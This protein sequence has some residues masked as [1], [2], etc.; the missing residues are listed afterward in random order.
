[1]CFLQIVWVSY[2][3]GQEFNEDD[4]FSD[5]D[6]V[7]DS[8]EMVDKSLDSQF[9]K[10]SISLSGSIFNTSS[11]TIKPDDFALLQYIL[12]VQNAQI[13]NQGL[14]TAVLSDVPMLNPDENPV[15]TSFMTGNV[16]LDARLKGG[17]KGLVNVEG[18]YYPQGEFDYSEATEVLRTSF[19]NEKIYTDYTLMEAFADFNILRRIYF[20]AGKQVLQWGRGLFFNPTDLINTDKRNLLDMNAGLSMDT[21]REGVYGVKMHIPFGTICNIYGFLNTG[22]DMEPDEFAWAGKIEFLLGDTEVALSGWTKKDY[23]PIYGLD[24]STGLFSMNFF[25]EISLSTEETLLRVQDNYTVSRIVYTWTP[26]MSFG[27]RKFFDHNNVPSR[28][29]LTGEVYYNYAGYEENIFESDGKIMALFSNGLYDINSLSKWYAIMMAAYREFIRDDMNLSCGALVNA[30]DQSY[31]LITGLNYNF[32]D[33]LTFDLAFVNLGG[34]YNSEYA[35]FL[36]NTY[37]VQLVTKLIF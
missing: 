21:G 15:Y 16:I 8:E 28:V 2:V 34:S 35:F 9:N 3:F 4:L 22:E 37:R 10:R 17:F 29:I 7:V 20:R 33:H 14:N 11:C 36:G 26:R 1:M 31:I 32:N 18:Y 6:L 12:D 23:K 25:G 27:F 13:E 24:F 5:S 19:D 30:V